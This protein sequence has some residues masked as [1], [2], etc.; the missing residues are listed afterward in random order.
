M[1]QPT[2]LIAKLMANR[3][4]MHLPTV[5]I[6]LDQE[7]TAGAGCGRPA[8]YNPMLP[9]FGIPISTQPAIVS[10]LMIMLFS[11]PCG[12]KGNHK[13]LHLKSTIYS[14]LQALNQSAQHTCAL[15]NFLIIVS[16]LSSE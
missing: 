1:S 8:N 15:C 10:T 7:I 13:S 6:P 3:L 12:S 11:Q 4:R 5:L 16:M 2:T 14:T 9:V